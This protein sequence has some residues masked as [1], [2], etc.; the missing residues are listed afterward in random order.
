VDVLYGETEQAALVPNSAIYRHPRDGRVGVFV[1]A[2]DEALRNPEVSEQAPLGPLQLGEPLGPV[3]VRFVPASVIARGRV[4]SAIGGVE[5][6]Q[7]VVTLGHRLLASADE[8]QAIVQPT[9]W[10]HILELQ[11]MQSRD[12]LEVIREK[13]QQGEAESLE[14]N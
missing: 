12:L 9:A 2:I 5:Q 10:E 4:S 13:Q 3:T 1:A 11:Q 14:P 8:R 7:W 6:G